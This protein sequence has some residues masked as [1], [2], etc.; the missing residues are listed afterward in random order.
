[1][2]DFL[3]FES[4]STPEVSENQRDNA[5]YR[6]CVYSDLLEDE[7]FVSIA[8]ERR[9]D[10]FKESD[11]KNEINEQDDIYRSEL[12]DSSDIP[13][14]TIEGSLENWDQ[15]V[16]AEFDS[17]NQP[18]TKYEIDG[19][20]NKFFLIRADNNLAISITV[21]YEKENEIDDLSESNLTSIALKISNETRE[22]MPQAY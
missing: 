11:V 22:E 7:L 18:G 5:D 6:Q 3:D 21:T 8:I 9:E 19:L 14:P 4:I 12:D 1:M 13:D 16:V 17:L 10:I 15:H 2:E 20:T